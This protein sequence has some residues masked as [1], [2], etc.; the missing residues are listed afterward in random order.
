MVPL[1]ELPLGAGEKKPEG[2]LIWT[3]SRVPVPGL[4]FWLRSCCSDPA[5]AG[6]EDGEGWSISDL[7]THTWR[8]GEA[9]PG[10]EKGLGSPQSPSPCLKWIIK[11]RKRGFSY[12]QTVAGQG[13]WV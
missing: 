8:A 11:K 10:E 7:Q 6:D 2:F 3:K 13:E 1:G 12:R 4:G 9:Q 5:A